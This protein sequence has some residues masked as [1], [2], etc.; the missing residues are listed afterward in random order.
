MLDL[1]EMVPVRTEQPAAAADNGGRPEPVRDRKGMSLVRLQ[2]DAPDTHRYLSPVMDRVRRMSHRMSGNP[3]GLV[4]TVWTLFAQANVGLWLVVALNEKGAI[5]GHA[6]AMYDNWDGKPVGWVTQVEMDTPAGSALKDDFI[7]AIEGWVREMNVVL[8]KT[9]VPV[10]DLIMCTARDDD[11]WGRHAGFGFF[12]TL[13]KRE[14]K[15]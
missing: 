4:Q 15:L 10:K 3:D 14:V 5:I 12:R 11:A 2:R 9:G 6:L 1:P 13:R 8:V 7:D